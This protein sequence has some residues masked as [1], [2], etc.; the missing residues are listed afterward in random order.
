MCINL[1]NCKLVCMLHEEILELL[2]T[3]KSMTIFVQRTL[4]NKKSTICVFFYVFTAP[5]F[6]AGDELFSL[7]RLTMVNFCSRGN[8]TVLKVNEIYGNVLLM[9]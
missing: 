1:Q 9:A 8:C 5:S 3:P 2:D 4:F 7:V 6:S